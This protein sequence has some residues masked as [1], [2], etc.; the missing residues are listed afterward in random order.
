M[1]G[2][3]WIVV[4]RAGTDARAA[5]ESLAREHGF[6]LRHLYEH[7]LLGFAASLTPE[8]LAAVRRHPAVDYVEPDGE[9]R[10]LQAGSPES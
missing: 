2:G 5:A 6:T 10:A 8:Q 1:T 7:A 4:F 9:V 3:G